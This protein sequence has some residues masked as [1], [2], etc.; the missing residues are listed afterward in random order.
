MAGRRHSPGTAPRPGRRAAAV[1]SG[2]TTGSRTQRAGP[3]GGAL[4]ADTEAAINSARRGGQ[5]LSAEVQERFG[6]ALGGADLGD[7]RVHE[8]GRAARLNR[9]VGASAFTI[10]NDVFFRDGLPDTSTP[11]G[12]HLLAHELTHTVQQDGRTSIA[13]RTGVT[14]MIHRHSSW[15]HQMLGDMKPLELA[16]VGTWEDLIKQTTED[17]IGKKSTVFGKKQKTVAAVTVSF[18]PPGGSVRCRQEDVMHVLISELKRLKDWQEHPPRRA[19]TEKGRRQRR[20]TQRTP[21]STPT[22]GS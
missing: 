8:G 6:V 20:A 21:S 4:D 14:K 9:A 5:K 18:P 15:E 16:A 11:E 10:G 22:T 7:V 13:G 2:R 12:Q 17:V 19:T 1:S 3:D